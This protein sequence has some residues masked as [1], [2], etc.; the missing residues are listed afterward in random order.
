MDFDHLGTELKQKGAEEQTLGVQSLYRLT[1][2]NE[3]Q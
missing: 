1:R 2:I 3:T